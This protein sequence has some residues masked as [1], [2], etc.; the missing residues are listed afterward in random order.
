MLRKDASGVAAVEF[1]FFT[2]FLSFALLN[3]ADIAT[4]TYQRMQVENAAEMGAQ[5]V[6][7][8]C[9]L[10]EVPATT[11]CSGLSTTI[12]NAIGS[13]SL[14][15]RVSLV[16]GYPTEGW[17]CINSSGALQLM[18]GVSSKPVDC[19]AA[20]MATLQPGDYITVQV[21]FTYVPLFNGNMTVASL[22]PATVTK[23]A[24]MR[25]Q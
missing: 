14:G 9:D 8:A 16:S 1:S 21:T 12:T 11:N 5:A 13:T 23:T 3:V 20:G 10:S 24:M 19:S 4:Y 2:L 17:Y 15:S 18:S 25:L 7:A 22:L 6:F